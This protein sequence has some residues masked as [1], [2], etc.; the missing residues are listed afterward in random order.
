MLPYITILAGVLIKV[1]E[2]ALFWGYDGGDYD[3]EEL[4]KALEGLEEE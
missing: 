1:F 4:I 3:L 2:K